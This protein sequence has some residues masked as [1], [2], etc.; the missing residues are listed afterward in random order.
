M[1]ST[2]Y[3]CPATKVGKN[4]LEPHTGFSIRT[5]ARGAPKNSRTQTMAAE[6]RAGES[7]HRQLSGRIPL[8]VFFP[9]VLTTAILSFIHEYFHL[10]FSLIIFYN[11][12]SNLFSKLCAG[13]SFRTARYG[14][15]RSANMR[16]CRRELA[17]S[18]NLDG[19]EGGIS[20][21]LLSDV[22]HIL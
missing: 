1:S 16:S 4:A 6:I 11:Q 10:Y 5:S 14:Q 18:G 13:L 20:Y 2:T 21:S 15:Q 22:L 17:T 8:A 3:F 12:Y 7:T 9:I 19:A